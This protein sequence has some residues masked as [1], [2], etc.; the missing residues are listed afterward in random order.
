MTRASRFAGCRL[1]L[2]RKVRAAQVGGTAVQPM[3]LRLWSYETYES[4]FRRFCSL[5]LRRISVLTPQVQA[6]F[7]LPIRK[8]RPEKVVPGGDQSRHH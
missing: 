5:D 4:R 3:N 1:V 6:V 7:G 8:A 2:D